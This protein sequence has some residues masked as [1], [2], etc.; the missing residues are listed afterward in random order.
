MP[1]LRIDS[2]APGINTMSDDRK[3]LPDEA[4]V[5]RFSPHGEQ[6]HGLIGASAPMRAIFAALPRIAASA[7]PLLIGGEPGTGKDMLARTVHELSDRANSAFVTVDCSA[8]PGIQRRGALSDALQSARGGTLVLDGIGDLPPDLQARLL[9]ILRT[10]EFDVPGEGARQLDTRIVSITDTDLEASVE[11]GR[12]REALYYQLNVLRITAAPLRE[13]GRDVQLLADFFFTRFTSP[14]SRRR[15][16]GFAAEARLAMQQWSW[17][18][19]V[20]EL[21]NRVKRAIVTC[22]K[23]PLYSSDLGLDRENRIHGRLVM[24]LE[25]ARD[26][27][28]FSALLAALT[29]ANGEL[30]VAAEKLETSRVALFRLM[31]KHGIDVNSPQLVID[32]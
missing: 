10:G 14:S 26:A 23:G 7:S 2:V 3:P 28:E 8:L 21:V 22:E 27:A 12:M 25:E 6:N 19:N 32:R 5:S 29:A 13:R 9:R 17:P 15:V 16:V 31:Q 24:T 4:F 11:S 1:V 30:A 20:R 18:G